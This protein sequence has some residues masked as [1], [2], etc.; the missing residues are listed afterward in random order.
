LHNVLHLYSHRS[1][2]VFVC[3][4]GRLAWCMV[5]N[6]LFTVKDEIGA[7]LIELARHPS[8]GC[9]CSLHASSPHFMLL[10]NQIGKVWQQQ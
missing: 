8:D 3:Y 1:F 6:R 10:Q 5:L 9:C 2:L 7:R 4:S